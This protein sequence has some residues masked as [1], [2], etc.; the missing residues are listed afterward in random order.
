MPYDLRKSKPTSTSVL[1]LVI[2]LVGLLIRVT[3][4]LQVP[5]LVHPD[6]V[7]QTQEPAH[8]LAYGYGVISWEWRQGVRSWVLPAFL[9]CLM[10]ATDWMGTGSTGYLS[11][12]TIVLS[13]LSLTTIWFGFSW[14]NEPVV[15]A[16]QAFRKAPLSSTAAV[17][18]GLAFCALTSLFLALRLASQGYWS[19]DSGGLIAMNVLRCPRRSTQ[20]LPATAVL[21]RSLPLSE[22]RFLYASP[23]Q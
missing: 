9:A 1:L 18:A 7:F 11:A 8:R 17:V 22:A 19:V 14:P 23:A 20:G 16:L 6:E 21:E 10:R 2:L 3:V 15:A 13:L 4:H 5:S 12:I